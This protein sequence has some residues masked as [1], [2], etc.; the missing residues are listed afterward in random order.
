M[1]QA[2]AVDSQSNCGWAL[3][4]DWLTFLPRC[5]FGQDRSQTAEN[6]WPCWP[7]WFEILVN[8]FFFFF[9]REDDEWHSRKTSRFHLWLSRQQDWE[10]FSFSAAFTPISLR[11]VPLVFSWGSLKPRKRVRVGLTGDSH[12]DG[13]KGKGV[14]SSGPTSDHESHSISA[15]LRDPRNLKWKE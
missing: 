3:E 15:D 1:D 13:Y 9:K 10:L 14:W 8:F 2:Q 6:S 12:Q 4:P 7:I 5:R 11:A